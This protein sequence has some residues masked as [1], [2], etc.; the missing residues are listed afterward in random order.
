[1]II[2]YGVNGLWAIIDNVSEVKFLKKDYVD[3]VHEY[4]NNEILSVENDVKWNT[5]V[6]KMII[7]LGLN[8]Y[9]EA[10]EDVKF[11]ETLSS[12]MCYNTSLSIV[13]YTDKNN[14]RQC[15]V[16]NSSGYLLNDKGI[17]IERI[18]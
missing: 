5:K 1:M 10:P 15:I 16:F 18:G 11:D 13:F 7:H 6:R 14:L 9:N 4:D 12:H 3:A 8:E 2:K 17:T